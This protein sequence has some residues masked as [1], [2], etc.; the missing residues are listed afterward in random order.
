MARKTS[1]QTPDQAKISSHSGPRTSPKKGP[2]RRR[3]D[4]ALHAQ[5]I[6]KRGKPESQDRDPG[7]NEKLLN[8]IAQSNGI[9]HPVTARNTRLNN[10]GAG[11]FG[12]ANVLALAEEQFED[13]NSQIPND[14]PIE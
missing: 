6:E 1:E 7:A 13:S 9:N 10:N 4:N 8:A 12:F 11:A 3:S 2:Q 5:S 14:L